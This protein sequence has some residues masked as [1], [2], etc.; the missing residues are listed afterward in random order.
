M[1]IL[2]CGETFP[3]ARAMM[4]ER[5]PS[6]QLVVCHHAAIRDALDGVDVLV[7]L[8]ARIDRTLIDAGGFKLIQQFGTGLEGIDLDAAR[9]RGVWVANAAASA[10]A[11]AES[12]AE[13]ALLLTLAVLRQLPLAQA[14]V[15]HGVLGVPLGMAL[16]GRT[17]CIVG[18]GAVGQAVAARF[19]PFGVRLIGV[20]RHPD[21]ARAAALGLVHCY[22]FHERLTAF[23]EADVLVL[24]LPMTAD[25][26]DIVDAAAFAALPDGACLVNVARGGLVN[27]SA[28]LEAL[29]SG[30]LR[31]AGLDVYWQEPI[32]PDDP[33]LALPNVI[34]TAHVAGVTDRSYA[35]ITDAVIANIERLRRGEPPADRAA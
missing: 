32:S 25:S 1:R 15:R 31:G 12:V 23:A 13:H 27:Y 6:D 29:S 4:Q 5:L 17:V 34:A 7:P 9:D 20:T 26:R 14:N 35:G 24:C 19:A 3:M 2:F 8:M 33:I 11:N 28:A 21:R 10:G 22:A 16:T 18:L 30:R